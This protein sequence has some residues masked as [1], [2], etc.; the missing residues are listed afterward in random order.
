MMKFRGGFT[1]AA[2]LALS[3]TTATAAD[4]DSAP[5]ATVAWARA[6]P[7]GADAA[8]VYLTLTGGKAADRLTAART[9]RA[10]MVHL[11]VVEESG[12]LTKM[13]PLDGVDIP[14]GRIIVL[15]P[16]GTHLMLMGFD[17]PF[18]AGERFAL[19]LHF[20]R[21]GDRMVDVLVRPATAADPS[22]SE[23]H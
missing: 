12:G 3:M 11:H 20:A 13:R 10:A 6:T 5:V 8:A 2:L 19:T 7:P 17:K 23:S 1:L 14:A 15:A 16:Q 9:A 21:A 18:V 22:P 4:G